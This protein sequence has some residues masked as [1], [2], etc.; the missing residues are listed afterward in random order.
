MNRHIARRVLARLV[1]STAFAWTACS[2]SPTAPSQS[3]ASSAG[4][5]ANGVSP[6]T[7]AQCLGGLRAPACFNDVRL[8]AA[9]VGV[10]SMTSAPVLNGNQ[11]VLNSGPVVTLAW[12]T[13]ATGTPTSYIV[14]AS[15]TP[16]GPAD[17]A[18]FNTGSPT[19]SLTAPGVPNGTYYVRVRGVDAGGASAPSNEVQL[20]VGA[21]PG[22]AC[23]SAARS[24]AVSQSGGTVTFSW[25]APLS[26]A[27]ASYVIL[28][29]S[30]PN[31][32]NLA[33]VDT[34]STALTFSAAGVP[35]GT[36]YVRVHARSPSCAAPLFLSGASNEVVVTVGGGGGATP[37]WSGQ[38]QCR[39]EISGPSGYAHQETQT[40]IV[41]GPGQT[42]TTSRTGYPV[43]WSAQ[44]SGSGPGRSWSIN[45]SAAT[46]FTV[47]ILSSGIA[48]MDRTTAA[49]LIRGGIVSAPTSFDLY[50]MEFPSIT[51]ASPGATSAAGTW[52][53][54][55][56]GGDSPMQLGGSTGSLTCNWMLNF[57]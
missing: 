32:A 4:L 31:A 23:P 54:P 51:T 40:W 30:S 38:I 1:L 14:E 24:L 53:R 50:E 49:I 21:A 11:S 16:G 20:V 22:G 36:Y 57:R 43:Q 27:A 35:P 6:V 8:H 42:L 26:G 52:S 5:V 9:S 56:V 28:A 10:A 19:P 13:P 37:G 15:S 29:G 2:S 25:Q 45:S 34:A 41:G 48:T 39:T 47:T 44:G 12:T 7:L 55:T 18:N 33:N 17:L 46:D 3:A